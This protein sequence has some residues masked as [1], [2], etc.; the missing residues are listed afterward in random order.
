MRTLSAGQLFKSRAITKFYSFLTSHSIW[1]EQNLGLL[2]ELG[3]LPA[4][5]QIL[6]LGSGSGVGTRAIAES[7]A[8]RGHVHGLDFSEAMVAT[9]NKTSAAV[10]N[11]SYS[12]GDATSMPFADASMD[13]IVANSFLYLVPNREGVLEEVRR[14]LRKN[15]RVVF[16]EPRDE[17]SFPKAAL[18]A[19]RDLSPLV[20]SPL[21][22]LRMGAAMLAWRTV[23]GIEGRPKMHELRS[24]FAGAGFTSV[25]FTPTLGGIGHY[26][27]ATGS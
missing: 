27:V 5:P 7:L 20:R 6:D 13:F 3:E 22:A 17:G 15:G 16:M 23:S 1:K 21:S 2:N 9:A 8:G 10:K 12:H 4:N 26:V 25:H 18:H 19:T 24:L 11:L 14:V